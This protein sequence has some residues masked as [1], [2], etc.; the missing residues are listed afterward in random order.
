MIIGFMGLGLRTL[1]ICVYISSMRIWAPHDEESISVCQYI[2]TY[3]TLDSKAV[4][5]RQEPRG[6]RALGVLVPRRGV[7]VVAGGPQEGVGRGV[8]GEEVGWG[9][10]WGGAAAVVFMWKGGRVF[11]LVHV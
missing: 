3:E 6:Q 9:W 2:Y 11:R 7:G 5:T 10:G 4:R 8:E 1:R